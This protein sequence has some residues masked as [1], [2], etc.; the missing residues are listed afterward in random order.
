MNVSVVGMGY[1]GLVTGVCLA[2]TGHVVTCVDLDE[3]KVRLVASGS[4]PIHEA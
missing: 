3:E 2:E 1:V 4:A